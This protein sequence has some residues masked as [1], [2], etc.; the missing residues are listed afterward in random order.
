MTGTDPYRDR[1]PV[2]F[3]TLAQDEAVVERGLKDKIRATLGKAPFVEDAVAAYYCA[4]DAN[5]PLYVKALT[6]GA[7]AYF[8]APADVIPDFIA[9]LG[10][11]DDAA[12]LVA[13]IKAIG[14]HLRPEH[15]ERAREALGKGDTGAER[16]AGAGRP[17][18]G[19]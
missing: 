4:I 5:T 1:I 8:V 15:R 17:D 3:E 12:V 16:G 11:T 14:S 7:V 18:R 2:D 9:G 19:A 10:F 6:M 13:A